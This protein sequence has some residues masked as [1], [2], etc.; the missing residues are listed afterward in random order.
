MPVL[1]IEGDVSLYYEDVG[2]GPPVLFVHG[3]SG[4]HAL[5]EAQVAEFSADFRTI[6]LDLRGHGWSDKP[7]NGYTIERNARDIRAFVTALRLEKPSYV[8]FSMGAAIGLGLIDLYG[9]MFDRMVLVG[10]TPCWGRLPD[11]EHGH[12]QDQIS[13]WVDEV[14][15]NRPKWT[16]EA[17]RKMFYQEPDPMVR[18]WIWNQSMLLPLH[19]AIQAIDDSRRTDLRTALPKLDIPVGIFHGRHD[20][21]DYFEAAEYMAKRIKGA[22]LVVFESSGHACFLEEPARFNAELR[23]FLLRRR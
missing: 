4:T 2:S 5:W 15:A 8:G 17:A 22:S 12:P 14:K 11:F 23:S 6:T 7:M 19:A 18:M 1:R 21:M 10:G 16:Y 13:R 3:F 9:N 20:E